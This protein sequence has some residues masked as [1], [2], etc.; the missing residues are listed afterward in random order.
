MISKNKIAI[1]LLALEARFRKIS[2]QVVK[3]PFVKWEHWDNPNLTR[4]E[5]NK[6]LGNSKN[7]ML[8]RSHHNLQC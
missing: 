6:Y 2:N 8:Y 3:P 4:S 1:S 5:R 7:K